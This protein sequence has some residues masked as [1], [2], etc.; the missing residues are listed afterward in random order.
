MGIERIEIGAFCGAQQI[1]RL[2][3]HQNK[4]TSLPSL[5]PLKCRLMCLSLNNNNIGLVSNDSFK[6]FKKL[7][8]I[9]LSSNNLVQLPHLHW[10]RHSLVT[11]DASVNDIQSLDMIQS[12]GIFEALNLF[13]VTENKIRHFNVSILR[14]MPKLMRFYITRNELNHIDDF[15]RIYDEDIYL[16]NNPWHCGAELSWMGEED[17]VFERNLKC[18]TPD[19]LHDRA[20]ADMSEF[21]T[22]VTDVFRLKYVTKLNVAT[23]NLDTYFKQNTSVTT[24]LIRYV[25]NIP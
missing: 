16:S 7:S 5:C 3:L 19:C 9:N 14:H 11:F 23:F 20:I 13:S 2:L 8:Q 12:F 1:S 21:R 4:L 15:R 10:I 18:A 22:L 24:I 25:S 17:M 6:G